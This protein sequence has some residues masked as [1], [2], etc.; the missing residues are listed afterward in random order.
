MIVNQAFFFILADLGDWALVGKPV[1]V[2]AGEM[3]AARLGSNGSEKEGLAGD[4]SSS[5]VAHDTFFLSLG[6]GSVGEVGLEPG[7]PGCVGDGKGAEMVPM[8]LLFLLRESHRGA[9]VSA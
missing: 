3:G 4:P 8:D 9:I 7:G 1:A 6:T 5:F 2:V